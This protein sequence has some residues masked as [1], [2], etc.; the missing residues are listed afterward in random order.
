V[1]DAHGCG[2]P[3]DDVPPRSEPPP[4]DPES[5]FEAFRAD[6]ARLGRQFFDLTH[7]LRSDDVAGACALARRID[8]GAGSH[9][10][11]EEQD[12]YPRLRELLDGSEVDRMYEEHRTGKET[13][14]TLVGHDPA[15]PLGGDLRRRLVA[16]STLMSNHISECGELFGAVG[17]IGRDEQAELLQH[18]LEWRRRRPRWTE[19]TDRGE[20][21]TNRN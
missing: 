18:L 10:A 5:L 21:P 12:F 20:T 13:V 11:F 1:F 3:V 19:L 2:V 17:A 16:D 15:R 4:P 7:L 8:D 9:I 14:H 6:H